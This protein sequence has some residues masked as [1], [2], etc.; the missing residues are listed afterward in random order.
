[1]TDP[2]DHFTHSTTPYWQEILPED[3][4]SGARQPPY[5]FCYPARLPDGRI[6]ELP[7]RA[8][9]GGNR[10]VASLIANQASFHVIETLVSFMIPLARR[11]RPD[12]IVGLPTLGLSFAPAVA[13]ALGHQN[14]I[15]LGYS[16]KFWY[17]DDMSVPVRSITSPGGSKSLFIDPNMIP[18][19]S[20]KRVVIVDDA[21]S[22]GTTI[23]AAIALLD[24]VNCAVCGI[25][26]AMRQ[27][28]A[29]RA[30]L[31]AASPGMAALVASPVAGPVFDRHRDGWMPV[32]GTLD[33]ETL[34]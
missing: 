24:K 4:P 12:C 11:T 10:A 14:F 27:G 20:G 21:I 15:P 18:R 32:E 22:S 34:P 29:W 30:A 5:R 13:S 3:S 1:M 23:T 19:I 25:V 7:L 31:D 17:R 33:G 9:P 2:T 8:V 28:V 6:L 16:R 26:T